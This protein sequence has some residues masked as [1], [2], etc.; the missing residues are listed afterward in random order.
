MISDY[1]MKNSV[2]VL[3]SNYYSDN[4]INKNEMVEAST[5]Y[6]KEREA[7]DNNNNNNNKN[8]SETLRRRPL[9]RPKYIQEN[10]TEIHV[11]TEKKTGGVGMERF[12]LTQDRIQF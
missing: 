3:F 7:T 8:L 2:T 1:T 5:Y 4:Q 12:R 6:A 9:V 10:N 11:L